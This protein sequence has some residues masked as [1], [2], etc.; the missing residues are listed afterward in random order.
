MRMFQTGATRDSAEEKPIYNRFNS[1]L[2]EKRF[3][4]YMLVH[5][6]QADGQHRD[7]DNWKKGIPVDAYWDSLH[8]HYLDLC[9]ILEGYPEEAREPDIEKVLCAM[10]FNIN[11]MLLEVLKER[12]VRTNPTHDAHEQ[13]SQP[14]FDRIAAQWRE[15]IKED[16]R[17]E[18]EQAAKSHP[19]FE[20]SAVEWVK[21]EQRLDEA[22]RT[23]MTFEPEPEEP[24]F[25]DDHSPSGS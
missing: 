4:E 7:G 1:A 14:D 15:R 25:P 24:S 11:G 13:H 9:L 17:L 20:R 5:Q 2:V 10:R 8:R 19:G 18:L 22:F 3:G 6:V 12:T 23:L 16:R 21:E